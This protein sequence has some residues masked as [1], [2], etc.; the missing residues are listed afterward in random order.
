M[1]R[2]L[3]VLAALASTSLVFAALAGA[4]RTVVTGTGTLFGTGTS[5]TLTVRNTGTD[6]I[7]CVRYFAPAGTTITGVTGLGSPTSFD[8][9]FGAQGLTVGAG[10]STTFAFT[11]SQPISASNNGSLRLSTDCVTD[12]A[13]TISG[14]GSVPAPGAP[15]NCTALAGQVV[16][17]SM[18]VTNPHAKGALTMKFAVAWSMSCTTGSG[19]CV[20]QLALS[21]LQPAATVKPRLKPKSG[22]IRCVTNCGTSKKG[23]MR[24]TLVVPGYGS[25]AR[26]GKSLTVSMSRSCQGRTVGPQSFTFVFDNTGR[27]DLKKS[28]LS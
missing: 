17:G 23:V 8:T 24:F 11:T 15:C 26:G 14:P 16:P 7:A 25:D 2:R 6:V 4:A 12:V 21:P 20:G 22:K 28:K 5:Y 3:R 9:G 1:N 18:R 10:A 19:G 27:V 13:G